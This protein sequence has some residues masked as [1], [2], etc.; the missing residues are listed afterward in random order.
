MNPPRFELGGFK[1]FRYL[2]L[3]PWDR[4][5]LYL[6]SATEQYENKR[7]ESRSGF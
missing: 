1:Y 5:T 4:Y 3:T 7:Y 2:T 6:I